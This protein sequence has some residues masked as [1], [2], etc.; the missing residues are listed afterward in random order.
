MSEIDE[1]DDFHIG[2]SDEL[3]DNKLEDKMKKHSTAHY[4]LN[5]IANKDKTP[6]KH[7]MESTIKEIHEKKANL[8][9]TEKDYGDDEKDW[10]SV[11]CYTM[12]A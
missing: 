7:L 8:N 12:I 11:F 10:I 6:K 1:S 4:Q 2:S 3:E 5:Y 9:D